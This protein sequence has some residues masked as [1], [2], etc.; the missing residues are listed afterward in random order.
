VGTLLSL[1]SIRKRLL[2]RR[3]GAGANVSRQRLL[4][5][6]VYVNQ[7][8]Y[9]VRLRE[10]PMIG[11]TIEV[12]FPVRVLESKDVAGGGVLVVAEKVDEDAAL[13]ARR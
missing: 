7:Q 2:N 1:S 12:G 11:A 3:L 6:V 8:S 13:G 10:K 9:S 4:A 5:A